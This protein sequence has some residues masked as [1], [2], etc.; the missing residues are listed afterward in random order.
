MNRH[1]LAAALIFAIL[2][3]ITACGG[4]VDQATSI[5]T[6]RT[7]IKPVFQVKPQP[8]ALMLRLTSPE[9]NQVTDLDHVTVSGMTSPDA[10]LSVNGRLA[11][12]DPGGLFSVDV[13]F[14]HISNQQEDNRLLCKL[15][16]RRRA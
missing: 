8:Q 12:P 14:S 16:K 11:L 6:P 1:R 10:T 9:V 3:L 15:C 4:G 2:G 7:Q 5:A 13:G